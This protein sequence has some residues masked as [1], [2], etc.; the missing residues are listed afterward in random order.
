MSGRRSERFANLSGAPP[1][2]PGAREITALLQSWR[3]GE[4][5]VADAL[6]EKVYLRLR[7]IAGGL[8]AHEERFDLPQATELVHEAYLRLLAQRSFDWRNREHFYSV[9]ATT[10]RRILVDRVR[11]AGYQKRGG[12]RVRVPLEDWHAVVS[13]PAAELVALDRALEALARLD[14]RKATIVELRCFAELSLEETAQALGCSTVTV[15]REQKVA[16]AW[17]RRE[18]E[19]GRGRES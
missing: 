19:G 15:S 16:K 8:L 17:L 6:F 10:M 1:R 4:D 14:P 12:G 3:R 7:R 5:G 2:S 11:S 18:L 9:A 13:L